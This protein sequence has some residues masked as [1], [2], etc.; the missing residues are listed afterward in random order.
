MELAVE[1]RHLDVDDGVAEHAGGGHRLLDALLHGR[2]ELAGDGPTDDGVGE[3]EAAAPGERLHAEK[4]HAE[5]TVPTGLLL[6][7]A[8][9]LRGGADRLAISDNDVLSLHLDAE[10]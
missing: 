3:I 9:G 7:L 1:A 6:V 4:R 10:L 8:L 2:D 5:L